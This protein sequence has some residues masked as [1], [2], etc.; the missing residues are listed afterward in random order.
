MGSDLRIQRSDP[1]LIR[2]YLEAEADRISRSNAKGD[3]IPCPCLV[4]SA[5]KDDTDENREGQGIM[6]PKVIYGQK[7]NKLTMIFNF[8]IYV[9]EY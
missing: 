5:P 2:F 8:D 3:T 6:S 7:P 1:H 9:D 4:G